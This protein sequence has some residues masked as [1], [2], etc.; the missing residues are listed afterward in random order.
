MNPT[1][2]APA[3]TQKSAPLRGFRVFL[4]CKPAR[5]IAGR[6]PPAEPTIKTKRSTAPKDNFSGAVG[7]FLG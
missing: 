4:F 6:P 3:A 1:N 7:F 5:A 2:K